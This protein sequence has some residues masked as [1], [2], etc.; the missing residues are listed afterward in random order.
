MSACYKTSFSARCGRE[1]GSLIAGLVERAFDDPRY[2]RYRYQPDCQLLY[3]HEDSQRRDSV[4]SLT[5]ASSSLSTLSSSPPPPP[6]PSSTN[7]K[8]SHRRQR[9]GR[10]GKR[11]T[12]RA[13]RSF[14]GGDRYEVFLEA[15]QS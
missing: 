14:A 8:R 2:T 15:R 6:S 7:R 10:T 13:A 11:V 9:A 5:D 12:S 1:A 3:Q 4:N